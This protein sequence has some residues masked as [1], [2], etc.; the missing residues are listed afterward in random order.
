MPQF[1]YY[2]NYGNLSSKIYLPHALRWIKGEKVQGIETNEEQV[3]TLKV[4]FDFVNLDLQESMELGKDPKVVAI[5][6]N[7]NSTEASP[8]EIKKVENDKEHRSILLQSAG[9]YLTQK[10]KDWW[11]RWEF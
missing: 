4:L 9:G 6:R 7:R 10:F 1:V 2:S 11:R 3:R 8:E 5:Q